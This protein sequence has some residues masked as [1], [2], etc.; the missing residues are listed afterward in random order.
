MCIISVRA[1]ACYSVIS[2]RS[3]SIRCGKTGLVSVMSAAISLSIALA[4]D[5]IMRESKNVVRREAFV[6]VVDESLL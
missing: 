3:R 1:P 5:V 4:R 6:L 2:I